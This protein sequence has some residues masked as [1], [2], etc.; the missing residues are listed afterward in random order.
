VYRARLRRHE[1]REERRRQEAAEEEANW[2]QKWASGEMTTEEEDFWTGEEDT[3]EVQVAEDWF[4]EDWSGMADTAGEGQDEEKTH[5]WVKTCE[6]LVEFAGVMV[7]EDLVLG[8]G[9]VETDEEELVALG[10]SL[11]ELAFPE[12]GDYEDLFGDKATEG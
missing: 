3:E 9:L 4:A 2:E 8:A 6:R 10:I 11:L 5:R 7:D 12:L 1:E